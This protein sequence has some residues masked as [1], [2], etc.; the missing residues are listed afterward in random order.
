M[1]VKKKDE[2]GESNWESNR[3]ISKEETGLYIS[4][5]GSTFF[6]AKKTTNYLTDMT[7][8]CIF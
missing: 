3:E 1:K 2:D 7:T 4:K 5:N 6:F 8:C